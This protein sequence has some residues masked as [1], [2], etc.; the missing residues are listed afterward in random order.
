MTSP[1]AICGDETTAPERWN[2]T[3]CHECASR[4]VL[5]A[6]HCERADCRWTTTEEGREY[7]RGGVKQSIQ[8]ACN[9]HETTTRVI[10]RDH[11]HLAEWWEMDHPD[12]EEYLP[13]EVD[14]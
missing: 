8:R 4:P 1:C 2:R 10:R 11:G 12:R 5:F 13:S 9:N 6:A 3:V 7:K 14:Q